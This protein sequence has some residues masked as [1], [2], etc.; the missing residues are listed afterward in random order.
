MTRRKSIQVHKGASIS[1]AGQDMS[2]T[3]IRNISYSQSEQIDGIEQPHYGTYINLEGADLTG[4]DL[5]N[6]MLYRST[7]GLR[8]KDAN[9]TN[10]DLS[11]MRKSYERVHVA[12]WVSLDGCVYGHVDFAQHD[13]GAINLYNAKVKN[14]CF[15]ESTM[16][17]AD[18]RTIN[19]NDK[20]N[21]WWHTDLR[22]AIFSSREQ[23]EAAH[24]AGAY[25]D[26]IPNIQMIK[27]VDGDFGTPDEQDAHFKRLDR[28]RPAGTTYADALQH[29][30]K[31][32]AKSAADVRTA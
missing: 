14:V 2:N 4:A 15:N 16:H 22:G 12:S 13:L 21:R 11:V 20:S 6:S 29:E 24:K 3:S 23:H 32:A 19:F 30:R 28:K 7:T 1:F 10:V 8:L 18:V 9:L 31:A 27:A 25:V 5:T 26:M 17:G